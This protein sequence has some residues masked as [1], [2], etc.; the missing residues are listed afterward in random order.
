MMGLRGRILYYDI[1]TVFYSLEIL[2]EKLAE[3][4]H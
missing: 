3:R 1:G 4:Q 2:I